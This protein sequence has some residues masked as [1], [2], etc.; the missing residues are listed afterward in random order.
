MARA[1][2]RGGRYAGYRSPLPKW[3]SILEEHNAEI[4]VN[5]KVNLNAL[6]NCRTGAK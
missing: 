2:V 5:V 1:N 6:A 3:S 4:D